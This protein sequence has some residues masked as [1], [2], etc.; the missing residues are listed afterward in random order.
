MVLDPTGRFAY[1]ASSMYTGGY[2][3]FAQ[4]TGFSVNALSGALTPFSSPAFTDSVNSNG[5]QLVISNGLLPTNPVPM[6][7]S[8]NPPS[9]IATDAAFTLLVNGASFVPGSAVYFGGQ[10]RSTTFVNSTQLSASIL[11]SD[12]DNDGNVVVFVFNPLPGGGASTSVEFPVSALVPTISAVI[13]TA[14]TATPL[15]FGMIIGG[16]NFVTSSVIYFNGAPQNTLYF[17][18]TFL[19]GFCLAGDAVTPGSATISV[20]TPPNGVPG[21]GTSNPVAISIIPPVAQLSVSGISPS[22]TMAGGPGVILTVTGNGFV[23]GSQVSFD[24]L[25]VPTTL[26]SSTELLASIPAS[27]IAVAGNPYVIVTNPG[28]VA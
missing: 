4:I 7:S 22:S 13:P 19:F 12:V 14:V 5:A 15:D 6:I 24:L 1:S 10:F 18:P 8:L 25:N 20:I 2:T 17:G 21:G 3:S 27:A 11:A 26:I 9:T 23:Q 16:T 28:G